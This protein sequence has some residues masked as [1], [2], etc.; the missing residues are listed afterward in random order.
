MEG[1]VQIAPGATGCAHDQRTIGNRL[2]Q[3]LE[4]LGRGEDRF[5]IHG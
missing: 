3:L 5:S 1:L 4:L 2:G